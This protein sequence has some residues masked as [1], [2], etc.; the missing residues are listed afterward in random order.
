MPK[1]LEGR[2]R[3]DKS[4]RRVGVGRFSRPLKERGG[5]SVWNLVIV[6]SNFKS[7]SSL[8]V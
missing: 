5:Q 2:F 1:A 8:V 3:L 7:Y 4:E 6:T